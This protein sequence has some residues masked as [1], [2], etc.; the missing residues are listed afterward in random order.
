M[1]TKNHNHMRYSSWDT[2]N[3]KMNISKKLKQPLE[4]PSFYT[5]APKIMTIAYTVPEIWDVTDVIVIFHFGLILPFYPPKNI[6]R[7]HHFTQVYQKL[8]LDEVR[9]L[10]Y[11]AWQTDGETDVQKKWHIEVANA[12]CCQCWFPRQ[13]VSA[14]STRCGGWY[15]KCLIALLPDHMR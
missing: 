10:R 5:V 3:E 8:W 2:K 12:A 13:R 1:C 9:F 7:Y 11:G 15:L 4:I 6:W 14:L